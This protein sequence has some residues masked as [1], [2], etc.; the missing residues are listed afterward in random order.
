VAAVGLSN[1]LTKQK[2]TITKNDGTRR[3]RRIWRIHTNLYTYS[4]HRYYTRSLKMP[5]FSGGTEK[6]E[7]EPLD[8]VERIETHWK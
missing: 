7:L 6:D 3:L 2:P 5:T 8:S 1:K 4:V